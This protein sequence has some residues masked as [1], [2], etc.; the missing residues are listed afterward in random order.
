M[1]QKRLINILGRALGFY[2]TL[3]HW[4]TLVLDRWIWLRKRF[5][6]VSSVKVLDVGCGGGAFTVGLA[7]LDHQP[8]SLTY[9]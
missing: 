6:H 5:V 8:L 4:D 9:D 7:R 3:I 1:A 2:G